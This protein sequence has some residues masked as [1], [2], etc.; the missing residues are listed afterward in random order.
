MGPYSGTWWD[1]F[2]GGAVSNFTFSVT[3]ASVPVTLSVPTLLRSLSFYAGRPAHAGIVAPNLGQT[4]ASNT[5][6][7]NLPLVIT[8]S[9]GLPLTYSLSTTSALPAWLAFSGTNGTVPASGSITLYLG[10]NPAALW[11]GAHQFTLFVNTSDPSNAVTALTV[12]LTIPP[13]APRLLV[14]AAAPGQFVFRLLG[15]AGVPYI[16]QTS[17]DLAAWSAIST[18]TI[19]GG[20][21]N[22]TNPIM[23]APPSKFWRALWKP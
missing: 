4:V 20:G 2:G 23:P 8:N 10:L 1:T 9:G 5:P 17:P 7:F 15:D 6:A 22:I 18:N 19:A 3:N 13:A 11:P 16:V 14:L 21:L 12:S